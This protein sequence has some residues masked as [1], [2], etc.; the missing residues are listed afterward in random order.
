MRGSLRASVMFLNGEAVWDEVPF[1]GEEQACCRTQITEPFEKLLYN[2]MA[3][4]LP[5]GYFS[6]D[7]FFA[8]VG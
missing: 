5:A 4:K 1:E 3:L 6:T 7:D 8:E 2:A